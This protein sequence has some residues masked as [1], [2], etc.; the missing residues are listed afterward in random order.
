MR[1]IFTLL[2]GAFAIACFNCALG[3]S[4][5]PESPLD[6]VNE[7]SLEVFVGG[8]LATEHQHAKELFAGNQAGERAFNQ[9]LERA[10]AAKLKDAGIVVKENAR[11]TLWV[12]LFGGQFESSGCDSTVFFFIEVTVQDSRETHGDSPDTTRLGV[13]RTD[14]AKDALLKAA[15]ATVDEIVPSG[16]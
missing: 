4:L 11:H 1:L 15:V 5:T 2:T 3:S 10:I 14:I 6:N 9:E 13:A 16:K 8:S 7:V 12:K